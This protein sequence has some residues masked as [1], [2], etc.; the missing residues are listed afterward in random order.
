MVPNSWGYEIRADLRAKR[1]TEG[2][3]G[4]M[5][6]GRGQTKDREMAE[7]VGASRFMTKPGANSEVLSAVRELAGQ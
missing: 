5:V 2:R 6:A 1:D 7:R 3:P 4:L